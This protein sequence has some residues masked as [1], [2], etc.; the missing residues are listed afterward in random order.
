M[1]VVFLSS[2]I[3]L[4][5]FVCDK[6]K[7]DWLCFCFSS[8]LLARKGIYPVI[9]PGKASLRDM[10]LFPFLFGGLI[11]L[12]S[13]LLWLSLPLYLFWWALFF[14]IF[15]SFLCWCSASLFFSLQIVSPILVLLTCLG[16]CFLVL[17]L[18]VLMLC[19]FTKFF[20]SFLFIFFFLFV[21]F[22]LSCC[23]SFYFVSSFLL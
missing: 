21:L 6:K 16:F 20:L 18:L 13:L 11:L 2:F 1:F 23:C 4:W 3:L 7:L 8:C 15:F 9:P 14:N 17:V 5:L 19:I 22:D 10:F 12:L